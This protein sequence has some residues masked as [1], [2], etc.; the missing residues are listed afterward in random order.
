[1]FALSRSNSLLSARD[2]CLLLR[3][4]RQFRHKS[5]PA[6]RKAFALRACTRYAGPS[7]AENGAKV[8]PGLSTFGGAAVAEKYVT[9]GLWFSTNLTISRAE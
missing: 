1:M 2:Y 3:L 9:T 6:V 7:R 8:F 4:L 5:R